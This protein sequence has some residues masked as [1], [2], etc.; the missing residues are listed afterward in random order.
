MCIAILLPEGKVLDRDTLIR[1]N[2]TNRDGF[3]Y[4]YFDENNQIKMVKESNKKK[5]IKNIDNFIETRDKYIDKPFLVHFRIATHGLISKR[6]THPFVVNDEIVFC[7]NGILRHDY[8]VSKTSNDSDTMMFNKKILQRIAKSCL[9][10][11]IE[12]KNDVLFQLIEGYIGSSNKMILL[13]KN[14]KYKIINE[15]AGVWDNG[16]WYSNTSYQKPEPVS[17]SYW[18]GGY[19]DNEQQAWMEWDKI[20]QTYK[21]QKNILNWR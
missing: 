10:D 5:I 14:G 1:C 6:C 21:P 8:G 18:Y 16:I 3:G 7:H 20:T 9:N 13:N 11:M 17:Y 19:W 4:A 2:E 12:G 15:K